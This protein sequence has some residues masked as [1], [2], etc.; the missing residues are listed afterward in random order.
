MFDDFRKSGKQYETV[1][2]SQTDQVLGSTGAAVRDMIVAAW[3]DSANTPVGY[4]MVNVRDIESGKVRPT[5]ELFG[6]D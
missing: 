5:P 2:A 4:P 6:A 1:A 3:L